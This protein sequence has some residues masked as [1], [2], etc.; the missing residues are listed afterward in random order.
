MHNTLSSIPHA[1]PPSLSPSS[2]SPIPPSLP[3][4][5]SPPLSLSLSLSPLSL[6]LQVL[7]LLFFDVSSAHCSPSQKD[8]IYS[9]ACP[10]SPAPLR[11]YDGRS[12]VSGGRGYHYRGFKRYFSSRTLSS[13]KDLSA[14]LR[15]A[16]NII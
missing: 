9:R 1:L 4:S 5:L 15:H 2:L 16:S 8:A 7:L 6:L 14:S 3:P 12:L 10:Q 11:A 13:L